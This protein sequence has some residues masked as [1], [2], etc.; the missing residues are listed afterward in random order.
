MLNKLLNNLQRINYKDVIDELYTYCPNTIKNKIPEANVQQAFVLDTVRQ[1]SNKEDKIL[2]VGAYEDTASETLKKL[3]YNITEIDP[4]DSIWSP[5]NYGNIIKTDLNDFYNN[6]K[7][8][9]YKIIFSTSVIEH[10]EDDEKFIDQICK[11]LDT[12]GYGILT[13]DFNESYKTGDRKPEV[14]Y[15]LYT[16]FDFTNRLFKILDNN[17]CEIIKP[18]DWSGTPDF[19]NGQ[20]IYSFATLVF[21]KK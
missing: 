17:N 4:L 12:N 18:Y 19:D 3:G 20:A 8:L 7:D 11:L 16:T 15:R 6:N 14:D 9:K 10:V 5:K 21:K 13:C 1:F 2:S